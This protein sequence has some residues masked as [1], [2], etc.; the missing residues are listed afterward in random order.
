MQSLAMLDAILS[1]NWE[2]RY[3]SFDNRWAS[4]KDGGEQMG[5][6]RDGTGAHYFAWFGRGGCWIKGFDHET[7]LSPFNSKPP[8]VVDGILTGVP[9]VFVGC[10]RE[11]AFVLEETTFCIWRRHD[12]QAWQH[13]PVFLPKDDPDPDGSGTLLAP[14]NG[15]PARYAKWATEYYEREVPLATVQAIYDFRPLDQQLVRSLTRRSI[16][17]LH[18][19]ISEIGY[20]TAGRDKRN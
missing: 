20:P 17:D 12:D 4:G 13:G 19:D 1:P 10:L 2:E 16:Q 18:A 11:P 6:M 14:L 7:R 9:S 5:S 15:D 3:F 8:R